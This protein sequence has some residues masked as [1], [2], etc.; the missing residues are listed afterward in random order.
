MRIAY[1][2][3]QEVAEGLDS[4]AAV[5]EVVSGLRDEGIEVDTFF[6]AYG[7]RGAPAPHVRLSEMVRL[8]LRLAR[9]LAGYDAVYVRAHPV[10]A[11]AAWAAERKGIPVVQE[12]NGKLDD[13]YVAWPATRPF[14]RV[15]EWLQ[16]IQYAWAACTVCVTP[17]L[18]DWVTALSGTTRTVVVPNGVNTDVFRDSAPRYPGLPDRYA[19]F[20]GNFAP[21]QGIDVLISAFESDT[22]PDDLPLVFVGDGVMRPEV[23]RARDRHPG[24]LFYVGRVPYDEMSSVVANAVLSVVPIYSPERADAG[25]SPL[26]LYESMACGLPVVVADTGGLAEAVARYECGAHFAVGDAEDLA[27]TVAQL[28]ASPETLS[29]AG[30]RARSAA[31]TECSWRAR[32]A[33]RAE[34]LREVTERRI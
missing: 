1:L 11:L 9:S 33:A 14:A 24:H 27:R 18:A 21:W 29:V 26:K 3:L 12:C 30:E 28:T 34:V 6:P 32:T 15:F 23:E 25:F 19:V 17:E 16:R 4:W 10:G 20:F 7:R 8:Q 22:W 31:V 2:S 13:L 5:N